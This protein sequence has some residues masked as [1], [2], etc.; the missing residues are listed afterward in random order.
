[1]LFYVEIGMWFLESLILLFI[2]FFGFV[3]SRI[4]L[5]VFRVVI[6]VMVRVK[7]E[8]MCCLLVSVF[9][10]DLGV[11]FIFLFCGDLEILFD[12]VGL[13]LVRIVVI[14]LEIWFV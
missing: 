13:S 5:M 9:V 2:L 12:F 1:M 6:F 14:I 3:I 8:L 4:D 7:R 11:L 10:D